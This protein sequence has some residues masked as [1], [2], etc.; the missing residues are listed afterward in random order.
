MIRTRV[1][2]YLRWK[3]GWLAYSITTIDPSWV[4]G[5]QWDW[6]QGYD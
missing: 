3:M 4:K 1:G 6:D 2:F 5:T